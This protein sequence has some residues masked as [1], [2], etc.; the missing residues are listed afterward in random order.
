MNPHARLAELLPCPTPCVL[1]GRPCVVSALTL[2]GLARL[3][4]L[5]DSARG[6]FAASL[7]AA[8][9]AGDPDALRACHGRAEEAGGRSWRALATDA[10]RRTYLLLCVSPLD[11]EPLDVGALGDAMT[12]EE[13]ALLDR[14][15][16]GDDDLGNAEDAIDRYLGIDPAATRAAADDSRS[17]TWAE[18]VAE[19]CVSLGKTPAEVGTLTPAQAGLLRRGG[20]AAE[21]EYSMDDA[22]QGRRAAFWEATDGD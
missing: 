9:A 7:A 20:K 16:R 6:D 14:V 11:G 13:W 17:V 22:I 3:A 4:A 2:A 8:E 1:A 10:G 15:A 12:P 21:R 19:L 5:D 18:V